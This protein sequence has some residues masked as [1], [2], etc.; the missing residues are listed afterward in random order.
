MLER[1]TVHD[2]WMVRLSRWRVD[3][4]WLGVLVVPFA[5]PTAH[6]IAVALPFVAT[7]VLLRAWARGHL[8]RARKVTQTGPYAYLRH[9]LYV[10]SFCIALGFAVSMRVPLLTPLVAVLFLVMYVPKAL[11]EEAWMRERFGVEYDAYANRV[12]AVVPRLPASTEFRWRRV[13]E[14]REW[15]TWAGVVAL[16][17]LLCLRAAVHAHGAARSDRSARV[18]APFAV[19]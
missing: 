17:A 14:H 9:P 11:R 4:A 1:D 16:L 19:R 15:K 8:D 6:S 3:L 12:G 7:G 18:A 2:R 10:G 13:V 5:R